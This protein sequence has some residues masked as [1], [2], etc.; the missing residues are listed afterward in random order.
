MTTS[1]STTLTILDTGGGLT[2]PPKGTLIHGSSSDAAPGRTLHQLYSHLGQSLGAQAN[3][4]AHSLGMGPLAISQHIE[5]FFGIGDQRLTKLDEM[6][7]TEYSSLARKCV[8]LV[9][10]TLPRETARTQVQAFKGLVTIITR[11]P[12]TRALFLKSHHLNRAGNTEKAISALW[13]R[14]DDTCTADW[15]FCSVL[16][17]GCM[18][19][20]DISSIVANVPVRSLG[21]VHFETGALSPIERLIVAS[22]C[23]DPSTVPGALALRY[24]GGA[25]ELPTFWLES[26]PIHVAIFTKILGRLTCALKDLGMD[27]GDNVDKFETP[28]QPLIFD[29]EGIDSTA[30]AILTVISARATANPTSEYWYRDVAQIVQLLRG[31][32]VTRRDYVAAFVGPCDGSVPDEYNPEC[33][34]ARDARYIDDGPKAPLLNTL[35]NNKVL[36]TG[37]I[38]ADTSLFSI[39]EPFDHPVEQLSGRVSVADE[40]EGVYDDTVSLQWAAPGKTLLGIRRWS[41]R[42]PRLDSTAVARRGI[43]K[44][45]HTLFSRS[46]KPRPP[47]P[48]SESTPSHRE[49]LVSD[50]SIPLDPRVDDLEMLETDA[51]SRPQSLRSQAASF[52]GWTSIHSHSINDVRAAAVSVN[53]LDLPLNVPFVTPAAIVR[54]DP[55]LGLM[56]NNPSWVDLPTRSQHMDL[57]KYPWKRQ[58]YWVHSPDPSKDELG[59]PATPS[60]IESEITLSRQPYDDREG[61]IST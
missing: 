43:R 37:T 13:A 39:G 41:W 33:R 6:R 2:V 14:S 31:S 21:S 17:A 12:G 26:G 7:K 58:V 19:E 57:P 15:Q 18:S 47:P 8:K 59:F 42:R 53:S 61:S 34:C 11:Y 54:G 36:P 4:A 23:S 50:A 55:A 10:Y 20:E 35:R 48:E 60:P 27:L 51:E 45:L 22:E 44:W 1:I 3:R 38:Y 28:T 24:L 9:E 25:L 52:T 56:A 30:S 16:A 5:E 49:S 40:A 46:L 32:Q 29:T